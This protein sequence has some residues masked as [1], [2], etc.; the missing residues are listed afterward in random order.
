MSSRRRARELAVRMMYAKMS[1]GT[2]TREDGKVGGQEVAADYLAR[3]LSNL[4]PRCE[5]WDDI[6]AACSSRT[7]NDIDKMEWSILRLACHELSVEP[8]VPARVVI[9][10]YVRLARKYCS[11]EG[12]R[13]VNGMADRMARTIRRD[14]MLNL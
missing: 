4:W 2:P 11:A 1:G 9:D 6:I 10:E 5:E 8:T 13:F 7:L 12:Y 3:L 14:E